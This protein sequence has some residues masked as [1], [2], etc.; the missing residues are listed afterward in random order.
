[1]PRVFQQIYYICVLYTRVYIGYVNLRNKYIY[2]FYHCIY[3]YK[4]INTSVYVYIYINE[5]WCMH[6]YVEQN[7]Q[8]IG[9]VLFIS[10][11]AV[12]I[13]KPYC[14]CYYFM[15]IFL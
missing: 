15:T 4:Y 3:I 7:L 11:H 5:I 12:P 10:L 14:L 2:I 9:D 1:M 13:V 8:R 6:R